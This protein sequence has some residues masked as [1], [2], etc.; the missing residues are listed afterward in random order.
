M[1]IR[2]RKHSNKQLV[3]LIFQW[4]A[5]K[6]RQRTRAQEDQ[7]QLKSASQTSNIVK[8]RRKHDRYIS[9]ICLFHVWSQESLQ[10]PHLLDSADIFIFS[11][12]KKLQWTSKA[13]AS[14]IMIHLSSWFN[15]FSS[16]MFTETVMYKHIEANSLH[17]KAYLAINLF[18]LMCILLQL[19]SN[20]SYNIQ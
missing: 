18:V 20:V 9:T 12:E 15:I 11:R 14:F 6:P 5:I 10:S 8:Q 7:L 17:V 4:G 16:A 1:N 3:A 2:S 13:H 19:T